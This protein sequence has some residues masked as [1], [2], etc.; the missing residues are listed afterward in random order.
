[1]RFRLTAV[2]AAVAVL[3]A[4]GLLAVPASAANGPASVGCTTGSSCQIQL[5]KLVTL[6][7]DVL[8]AGGNGNPVDITPPPCLWN[9]I[10]DAH[11]GSQYVLNFYQNTD[12]G[13]GALY[14]GQA[15]FQQAQKLV[16]SDPITPGEWYWLPINPNASA[17]GQQECLNLPLY[18][19]APPGAPLPGLNIPPETLAQLAFAQLNT[20]TL[21]DPVLDPARANVD[22]NLP[23]FLDVQLAAPGGGQLRVANGRPYVAVT[24]SIPGQDSATVWAVPSDLNIDPGTS[25]ARTFNDPVCSTVHGADMMG[26]VYTAA[27]MGATGA[28]QSIDCGVTYT[29]PG[30]FTLQASIN[31]T[32]CWA[33]TG[34]ATTPPAPPAGCQNGPQVPGAGALQ[35]STTTTGVNVR[36]IQSVNNG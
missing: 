6:N 32:A 27:A 1:M 22:T 4:P 3:A 2:L 31:W 29:S 26:S 33:D 10:G 20:A 14:D 15:A 30:N 8:P 23:T 12:P 19:F 16:N 5:S 18:Y 7:G 9:P 25:A 11:A 35:P 21:G 24:A 34:A 17:A 13:P 28:G 36:E